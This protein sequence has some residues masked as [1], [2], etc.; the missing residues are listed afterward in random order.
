MS[1][2]G[3]GEHF[4]VLI[5]ASRGKRH[6]I[7]SD[8]KLWAAE[9]C[10]GFGVLLLL[11]A[12]GIAEADQ[13]GAVFALK[14]LQICQ[15]LL[16]RGSLGRAEAAAAATKRQILPD[17]T[18]NHTGNRGFIAPFAFDWTCSQGAPEPCAAMFCLQSW[19]ISLCQSPCVH[20]CSDCGALTALL[21]HCPAM[22]G[23]FGRATSA[24]G[25][26]LAGFL[27]KGTMEYLG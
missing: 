7:S 21:P 23:S 19:H 3:N 5:A 27:L 8:T 9:E 6:S 1:W 22:A 13:A 20:F 14:L 10:C 18:W 15:G 24:L 12:G 4:S 2:I 16:W 25:R 26:C 11:T 17:L